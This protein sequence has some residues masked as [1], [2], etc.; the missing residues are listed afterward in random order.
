MAQASGLLG[1][2]DL[3]GFSHPARFPAEVLQ[4]MRRHL[5]GY[6]RVLDLFAGTGRI[7][8]LADYGHETWGVEIEPEW[9]G[10]H[11]R[12]IVGNALHL[13][14]GDGTFDA[15]TTSCCYG[16]RLSDHHEAKDGSVRRSYTHD[17]GRALHPE[18]SGA[19]QWGNAYRRFHEV[20]WAESGRA[21]RIDGRLVLNIKNHIRAG[22]EVLVAE[23]HRATLERLGFE[24]LLTEPVSTRHL[25]Q[26]ENGHR[27][28]PELV[29]VF[30]WRGPR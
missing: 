10:L 3:G 6:S 1:K 16:N 25:K 8:I 18:N 20:A 15:V 4:I 9:A 24:W 2:P 19:M 5:A 22:R 21:L 29:M 7:H 11:P 30:N 28:G 27:A 17:L 23:W 12:T 13:P 14:F 26:G